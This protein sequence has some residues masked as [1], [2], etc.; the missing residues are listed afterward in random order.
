MSAVSIPLLMTAAIY[1]LALEENKT[2]VVSQYC[3]GA[4]RSSA[5]IRPV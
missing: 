3:A 5:Y 1:Q 2:A 4:N